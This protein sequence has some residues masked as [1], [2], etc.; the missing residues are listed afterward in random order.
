MNALVSVHLRGEPTFSVE[1]V[2]DAVTGVY[3]ILRIAD[4]DGS[5]VTIFGP[6]GAFDMISPTHATRD[7]GSRIATLAAP[8]DPQVEADNNIST[9]DEEVPF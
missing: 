3:D 2:I 4:K 7:D 9:E 1:H 8:L 6:V 5:A